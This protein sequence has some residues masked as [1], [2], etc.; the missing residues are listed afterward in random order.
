M[1]TERLP[2][3]ASPQT[4]WQ[5]GKKQTEFLVAV[6]AILPLALFVL[7]PLWTILRESVLRP[8]GRWSLDY[9]ARYIQDSHFRETVFNTLNVSIWATLATTAIAFGY[10]YALRRTK[11]PGKMLWHSVMLLPLFAPSLIQALGVQF[12]LGRNGIVNRYL[13]TDIDIYGFWGILL[14]NIL[15]GLP[16]AY[17]VLSVSLGSADARLYEA[18]K[19]L[20]AG[21]FK[22][23]LSVTLP[24]ARYGVLSAIFL[25][26]AINIS[27]FGNPMVLGGDY[28]VLAT[29]IYNQVA[30][31]ANFHLG[32]V[33]GVLLLFPVLLSVAAE[34]WI[35]RR[36]ATISSQATPYRPVRDWRIDGPM[37]LFL[38]MV[39]LAIVVV[40]GMVVVASFTKLWPYN[41]GFTLKHYALDVPGGYGALWVSL[42]MSLATA[43]IGMV[44]ATFAA[45]V[46]H[47][48]SSRLRQVLYLLSVV[49]A[50]VPGMVLGLG[51]VLA[52][53]NPSL[54]VYW[55]YGTVALLSLCTV[56]HY[57][58][59]AF[60][61]ATTG[62]KQVDSRLQEASHTLGGGALHT[63]RHVTLPLI[64]P[65]MASIGMFYF[66][67]S[68]VT[69]SALIFLV[70]PEVTPAAVSI[71]LLNDAGNWPQAAAFATI[72]MFTIAAVVLGIKA[73]AHS[74]AILHK[75]QNH[76]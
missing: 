48:L 68:M 32:A 42:K 11:V 74:A 70:S 20:G 41:L 38:G 66:M 3:T 27:E 25:G 43:V 12:I 9:Y 17:L 35:G 22:R 65:A 57:H 52:F 18:A 64:R 72:I 7:Y 51:Y 45:M 75:R 14:A 33:I 8:D 15:Y 55:L 13:G 1:S 39:A 31:Q 47:K 26:F 5:L 37:L 60:L 53:N 2:M 50:A 23:F 46:V 54:P 34:K 28:N 58:A 69:I 19:L 61:I 49:P 29:E 21:G 73:L 40:V 63:A 30:G 62:L 10:A 59:Q 36:Q 16:H 56:Y 24:T 76:S 6:V 71:L 67:H 44:V 4:R